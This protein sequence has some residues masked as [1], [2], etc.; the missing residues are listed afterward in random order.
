MLFNQKTADPDD[1]LAEVR[2]A[3]LLSLSQRTLQAWRAKGLGP[4][5]VR[6]DRAIR[7]RRR[8]LT[9]WEDANTVRPAQ[10]EGR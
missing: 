4:A 7:Y 6:A 10:T 1:L 2:A 9:A 8:D 5:Y 3:E